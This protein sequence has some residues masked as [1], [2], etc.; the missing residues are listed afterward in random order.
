MR[1][2]IKNII[3]KI[4]NKFGYEISPI[5]YHEYSNSIDNQNMFG[6]IF[7]FFPTPWKSRFILNDEIYGGDNDYSTLRISMLNL[8]GLSNYVIF[9]NK[10]ILELGPL[11][12][13]NSLLLERFNVKEIVSIEGRVESYI[14]CCLIKNLYSLNKTKYHLDD[15]RNVTKV[16]YG[17]F[18]IAVVLGLLYHL[19]DPFKMLEI[20]SEVAEV[21]VLS[22]H[23]A[24][25]ES[26]Y[27]DAEEMDL[28]TEKGIFKGRKYIEDPNSDPNA[29]LQNYS[30]WPYEKD[31]LKMCEAAG[32]THIDVLGKNPVENEQYKLI[33]LIAKK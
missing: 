31:L 5:I 3:K 22:T 6:N 30:F 14:K 19:D 10:R 27:F 2:L 7:H 33:Y 9:D 13:G 15:V 8:P 21:L 26:P 23:Y 29:G 25:S 12:G 24:D 4:L 18:D 11:E 16:K 1:K 28:K 32:Y 20:I 17:T